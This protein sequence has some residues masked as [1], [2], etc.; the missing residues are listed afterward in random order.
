MKERKL[1]S[2]D[3]GKVFFLFSMTLIMMFYKL[4]FILLVILK[5]CYFVFV[6]FFINSS[7]EN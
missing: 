7:N 3:S 1:I 6:T 4:L 5:L 2:R